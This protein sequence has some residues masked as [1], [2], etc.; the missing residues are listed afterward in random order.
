M[1]NYF[2]RSLVIDKVFNNSTTDIL[3]RNK[4][5]CLCTIMLEQGQTLN[6]FDDAEHHNKIMYNNNGEPVNITYGSNISGDLEFNFNN[7]C[8]II[9]NKPGTNPCKNKLWY[10]IIQANIFNMSFHSIKIP[11]PLESGHYISNGW[12]PLETYKQIT[13]TDSTTAY[14]SEWNIEYSSTADAILGV[15]TDNAYIKVNKLKNISSKSINYM[16]YEL[17]N[18]ETYQIYYRKL[19]SNSRIDSERSFLYLYSINIQYQ[20]YRLNAGITVIDD[21]TI[22]VYKDTSVSRYYTCVIKDK[23]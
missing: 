1:G 23:I 12:M 5:D 22:N 20:I 8:V 21:I 7:G 11:S 6:N 14:T 18:D 19:P 4:D 13:S 2:N 9:T 17:D 15:I 16:I 3:I 10:S